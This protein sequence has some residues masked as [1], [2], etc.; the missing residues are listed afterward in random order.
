MQVKTVDYTI[1]FLVLGLIVFGMIMIS[2]VSVYPSFQVTSKMLATGKIEEVN[3]HFYLVRNISHVIIWLFI[4]AFVAKTPY[5]WFERYAKPIFFGGI[6]LLIAALVV[7]VSYN[8]AK[9]WL[10][11]PFIPFSLQPVEFMK[12]GL[13]LY[14][15]TFLKK[16]KSQIY[17]FTEGFLPY[18]ALLSGIILLLVMQ[19]DFG[20]ILLI[21]PIAIGMFFIGWGNLKHLAIATLVAS[22]FAFSVYSIGSTNNKT[23]K[24]GYIAQRIDNFLSDNKTSIQN[25]SINF[26]TKQ[27]LIAI[28]SGGLFGLWFGKSVQKFGY[29]PEVQWDFIFSVI[30]EELGFLGVFLLLITFGVIGYRAFDIAAR[31]DDPFAKYVALW[32]GLWILTQAGVNIGVNLNILPLTGVT[33]P[34]VSYGGSSLISLLI[35]VG[36]LLNI[37]KSIKQ[38]DPYAAN[39]GSLDFGRRR[40]D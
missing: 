34:F 21:T 38:R 20:S 18:M 19:P 5:I 36:I 25:Q 31:V 16:K 12:L 27:G 33:L 1:F 30:S 24:L 3:N 14:F 29:L 10:D 8:G 39:Y 7:G 40:V 28:G 23:G 32:V 15:A 37:S 6:V 2:S 11:I 4:F 22:L 13:I 26:Q 17:S 9:W 35:G